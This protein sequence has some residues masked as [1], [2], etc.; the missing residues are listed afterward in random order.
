MPATERSFTADFPPAHLYL[1]TD[2]LINVLKPSDPH[3]GRSV[4]FLQRL[5]EHGLTRLYLSTVSWMEI[6]HRATREQYRLSLPPQVQQ[7]H[8][9]H[10]W[11]RPDVR[12][13]YIQAIIEM[14]EDILAPFEWTEI[15]VTPD[16]FRAAAQFMGQYNFEG[17]DAIHLACMQS[18]G[19]VDIASFDR[20]FR[21]VEWL[22]V[23]NDLIYG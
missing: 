22:Y 19:I 14:I 18:V 20:K 17:Q 7:E 15:S 5:I 21:R 12:H 13:G 10:Q 9:F 3:H 6:V 1:D 2:L 16:I 4:A 23:W 8:R 11:D